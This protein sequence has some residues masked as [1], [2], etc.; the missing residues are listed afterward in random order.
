[1]VSIGAAGRCAVS[2]ERS[3]WFPSA[4]LLRS[5]S[6]WVGV[7]LVRVGMMSPPFL[8]RWPLLDVGWFVAG[9]LV[10]G[11]RVWDWSPWFPSARLVVSLV[12]GALAAV[13]WL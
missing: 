5:C 3:P 10:G 11:V 4:R 13:D 8:L 7:W 2:V 12:G 1:M 9:R 6:M